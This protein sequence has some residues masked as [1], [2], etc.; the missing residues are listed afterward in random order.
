MERRAI[1][2]GRMVPSIRPS[3]RADVLPKTSLNIDQLIQN[4]SMEDVVTDA[5]VAKNEEEEMRDLQSEIL[6]RQRRSE[7]PAMR[8]PSPQ[9]GHKAQ[10]DEERLSP[11]EEAV[12]EKKAL[13][14]SH[15]YTSSPPPWQVVVSAFGSVYGIIGR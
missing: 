12:V 6:A 10:N 4:I 5:R 13:V 2:S 14:L 1:L 3:S 8:A 9:R 15:R 11:E 7:S